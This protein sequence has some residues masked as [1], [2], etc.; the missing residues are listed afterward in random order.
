MKREDIKK[1]LK[2][3]IRIVLYNVDRMPTLN[4]MYDW[5]ESQGV[6]QEEMFEIVTELFE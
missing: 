3:F 1:E 4:E 6:P 5:L 2:K